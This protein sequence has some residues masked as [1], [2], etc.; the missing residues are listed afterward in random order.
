MDTPRITRA[1]ATRERRITPL[2]RRMG[3]VR[4]ADFRSADNYLRN[5]PEM[6]RFLDHAIRDMD[7][8]KGRIVTE[9]ELRALLGPAE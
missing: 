9:E 5:H 7:A 1:M 4:H 8:G 3:T 2:L 6:A